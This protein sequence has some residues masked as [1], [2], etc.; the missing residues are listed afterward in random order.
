MITVFSY[1]SYVLNKSEM[2]PELVMG[3]KK[4]IIT[5]MYKIGKNPW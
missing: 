4:V 2:K 5:H 3:Y 1:V